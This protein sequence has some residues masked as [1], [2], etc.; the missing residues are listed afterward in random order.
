MAFDGAF[1]HC[2]V[3]EIEESAVGSRVD[4]IYQ[5]AKNVLVLLLRSKEFNGKL[6]LSAEPGGARLQLTQAGFENPAVPPMLCMLLRKKL[7]GAKLTA[8]RQPALERI[9]Y[10]DFDT[11]NEL[12]DPICL[13]LVAELMGRNANLILLSEQ[14][15][16]I[17]SVRRTDAADTTRIIMPGVTYTPPAKTGIFDLLE[18]PAQQAVASLGAEPRGTIATA[19]LQAVPGISPIVCRELAHLCVKGEEDTPPSQPELDAL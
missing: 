14:G 8:L 9:V 3:N 12:G 7:I 19:L 6:L 10:L 16:V 5:P 15:K 1:L 2:V 4:K 13:T 11:K 18:H 17:D